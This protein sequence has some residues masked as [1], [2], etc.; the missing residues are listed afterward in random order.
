MYQIGRLL[1]WIL[2]AANLL[3]VGIMLACAYSPYIDPVRHPVRACAGLAFP[4]FLC[5]TVAFLLFWL[6]VHVRYALLSVVGM[7]CCLPAIQTFCPLHLSREEA[8]E[9]SIKFLS[10][11][12]MGFEADHPDTPDNPNHVLAYLRDSGADIICMQEYS[13]G[14]RLKQEHIDHVLKDYPYKDIHTVGKGWNRLACYS[15]HPILSAEPVHYES[16]FNGSIVY[17]IAV[18]GDTLTVINNHLEPNKLTTNDRET[19]V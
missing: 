3:M 17:T 14:G 4:V 12:I 1:G 5:A 13:A 19:Y 16:E 2:L 8:P 6:V 11:N 9:G 15:R 18:E 10:Y 7:L